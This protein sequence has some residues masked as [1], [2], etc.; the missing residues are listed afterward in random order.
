MESY[1]PV[2]LL[3]LAEATFHASYLVTQWTKALAASVTTNDIAVREPPLSEEAR[4]ARESIHQRYQGQTRMVGM[5]KELRA[6]YPDLSSTEEAMIRR[7]GVPAHSARPSADVAA[8]GTDLNA[9]AVLE[10]L[11]AKLAETTDATVVFVFLDQILTPWWLKLTHGR[12]IN[13]HSAV[14]PYAR[15]M[16]ALEQIAITQDIDRFTC[17][18]GA[19]V[20][21]VDSGIDTGP[22]IRAERVCDPFRFDSLWD[23][24]GYIFTR[25][26]ELLV[27]VAQGIVTQP[28][29]FPVGT[30]PAPELRGPNFIRRD[31]T[32][33]A[34]ILAAQGYL[35]MKARRAA[36]T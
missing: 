3:L 30:P 34:S 8:L 1:M 25:V 7:F 27:Q 18:A 2:R 36:Q 32:P 20:H 4:H 22:I 28:E 17:A 16:F 19:S 11:S 23:A 15:G 9:P 29:M 14:L 6:A 24:K 26:F 33:A 5:V 12:I 35:V 21:Y 31:F 10:W 13:G